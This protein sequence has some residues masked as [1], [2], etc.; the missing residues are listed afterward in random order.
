[1]HPEDCFRSGDDPSFRTELSLNLAHDTTPPEPHQLEGKEKL[2]ALLPL[3]NS[4][5]CELEIPT[6]YLHTF[7]VK[8]VEFRDQNYSS[9]LHNKDVHVAGRFEALAEIDLDVAIDAETLKEGSF[10]L[11]VV[12]FGVHDGIKTGTEDIA[13]KT[14][15][16]ILWLVRKVG[17]YYERIGITGVDLD[18][19]LK[20]DSVELK[21]MTVR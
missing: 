14:Y 15:C 16:A 9:L 6:L 21:W 19:W 20:L 10:E 13:P 1:V 3:H 8:V 4:K 2:K 11:A 18:H 12:G 17:F 7:C 5:N